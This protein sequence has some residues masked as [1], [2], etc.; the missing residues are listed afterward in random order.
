MPIVRIS[1]GEG[2]T[3]EETKELVSQLQSDSDVKT[4]KEVKD[5]SIIGAI[6]IAK[7]IVDVVSTSIPVIQK[8]HK[9]LK[10]TGKEVSLEFTLGE[11]KQKV[12]IKGTMTSEEVAALIKKVSG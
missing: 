2:I 12:S 8:L 4:V 1:L 6:G 5:R 7:L 3:E 9:T 10:K 11:S